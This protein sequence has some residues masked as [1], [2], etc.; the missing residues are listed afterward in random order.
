LHILTFL[1][2]SPNA[3]AEE[4][5]MLRE[6]RWGEIKEEIALK[7]SFMLARKYVSEF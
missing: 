5:P 3:V 7:N 2:K 6:P 4:Y 1:G